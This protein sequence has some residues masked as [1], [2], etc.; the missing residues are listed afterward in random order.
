MAR[1]ILVPRTIHFEWGVTTAALESALDDD[2]TVI[3]FVQPPPDSPSFLIDV[4]HDDDDDQRVDFT[5]R[6]LGPDVIVT[7]GRFGTATWEGSKRQTIGD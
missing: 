5:L 4:C 2:G 6:R 7:K 3:E 1:K